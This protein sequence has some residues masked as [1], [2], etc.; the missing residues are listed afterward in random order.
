MLI[1]LAILFVVAWVFGYFM[2]HVLGTLIH[3]LLVF[4]AITL[5]FHFLR[6]SK[7]AVV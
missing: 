4:A 7:G 2:F 1:V 3:L 5:V 6:S